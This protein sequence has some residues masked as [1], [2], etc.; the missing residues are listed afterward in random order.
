MSATLAQLYRTPL[1][2]V[3]VIGAR[4]GRII[5]PQSLVTIHVGVARHQFAHAFE[6]RIPVAACHASASQSTRL[7]VFIASERNTV[8]A[9]PHT[10]ARR[11]VGRRAASVLNCGRM[12]F[13]RFTNRRPVDVVT[14]LTVLRAGTR[15]VVGLQNHLRSAAHHRATS[16]LDE[17][18]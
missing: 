15:R 14:C 13:T 8:V 7:P 12:L 6:P 17:D 11:P 9:E 3:K 10:V 5:F 1:L 4:T 16:W 18:L 2:T